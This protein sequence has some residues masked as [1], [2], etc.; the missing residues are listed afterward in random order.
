[1]SISA[2]PWKSGPIYYKDLPSDSSA[3][4]EVEDEPIYS[5]PSPLSAGGFPEIDEETF[6]S[7]VENTVSQF[8]EPVG[9]DGKTRIDKISYFDIGAGVNCQYG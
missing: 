2:L 3:D 6:P 4:Q 5:P 8:V 7:A 1:M 9:T